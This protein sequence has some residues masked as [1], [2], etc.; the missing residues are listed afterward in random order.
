[1]NLR[2]K[3]QPAPL[4]TEKQ[5]AKR[6]SIPWLALSGGIGFGI[7]GAIGGAIW[8]A[9]EV[10]QVGFAVLGAAGGVSLGLALEGWKRAVVL[11]LAGAIG[12]GVGF[13]IGF[14]IV[15]AVWEPMY[16]IEGLFLGAVGGSV[17]GASLGL[18]LRN[19]RKAGLLALAGAVGFGVAV[20]VSWDLFRD[21]NPVVLGG[22]M[23]LVIWGIVGGGSLGAALGYLER[24]RQID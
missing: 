24:K 22:V 23:K 16:Y 19:W 2:S 15:L 9:F 3:E 8:F 20:Q 6:K 11:A 14:F 13:L 17:G 1:M 5:T 10:P 4:R 21:L 7:G 18:A 12:F